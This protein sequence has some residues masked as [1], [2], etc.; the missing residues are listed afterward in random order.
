MRE[1]SAKEV[2]S[3]GNNFSI[4]FM[5]FDMSPPLC[6]RTVDSSITI[7]ILSKVPGLNI[8]ELE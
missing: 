4:L 3:S 8:N 6:V 7:I 2:N 1:E 5:I